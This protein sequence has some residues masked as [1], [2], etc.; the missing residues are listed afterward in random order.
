M[1]I[2]VTSRGAIRAPPGLAPP[3]DL[4]IED[5]WSNAST[6][7]G[8]APPLGLEIEDMGS[9]A[10]TSPGAFRAPPG[11]APPLGLE[12]EDMGS[13][14][15]TSPGAFR[16]PPGLAPPLD[17]QACWS[18]A[19]FASLASAPPAWPMWGLTPCYA[20]QLPVDDG[21]QQQYSEASTCSKAKA[22]RLRAKRVRHHIWEQNQQQVLASAADASL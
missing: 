19:P 5:V 14:A 1:K 7:P 21:T 22:R 9:N 15:S 13:N 2:I 8:L 20:H 17:L 11:L 12:I 10:S 18:V 16:A 4:E 6:S 3:L